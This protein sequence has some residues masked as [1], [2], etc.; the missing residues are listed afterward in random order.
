[1]FCPSLSSK[2]SIIPEKE[3]GTKFLLSHSFMSETL[4][5]Q[6]DSE[7]CF[8]FHDKQIRSINYLF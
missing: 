5:E 8:T 3:I 2:T 7:S 4:G 1:M 6:N